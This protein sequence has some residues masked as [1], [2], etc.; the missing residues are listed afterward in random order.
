[1]STVST[2]STVSTMST[3]STVSTV[4]ARCYLHLRWY[5]LNPKAG[6]LV[7]SKDWGSLKPFI[8]SKFM[9]II[10]H[11]QISSVWRSMVEE[12]LSFWYFLPSPAT[13]PLPPAPRDELQIKSNHCV[14]M[15]LSPTLL[16]IIK[17]ILADQFVIYES[18]T[19]SADETLYLCTLGSLRFWSKSVI[20]SLL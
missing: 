1:M 5:F 10:I 11:I 12:V 4:V 7:L 2:V 15:C 3:V 14:M 19:V 18:H 16:I 20:A 8:L 13:S 17:T 6:V 9:Q